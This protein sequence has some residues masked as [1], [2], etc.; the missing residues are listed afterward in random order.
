MAN[1]LQTK[2]DA[3]LA[4]KNA[5]LSPSNLKKGITLLGV[6]GTLGGGVDLTTTNLTPEELLEKSI[7]YGTFYEL[8]TNET[9]LTGAMK[10][11]TGKYVP[12]INTPSNVIIDGMFEDASNLVGTNKI[13]TYI[14]LNALITVSN[15]A[16]MKGTFKN[17]TSITRLNISQTTGLF[18]DLTSLFEGCTALVDPTIK[19]DN[20]KIMNRMY[21]GC[22]SLTTPGW[23]MANPFED[24]TDAFVGC[25][26]LT[27]S[28]FARIAAHLANS[29][30]TY[31]GVRTL[32]AIGLT[33]SQAS[34][35]VSNASSS[36]YSSQWS[37]MQSNGWTTGY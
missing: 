11:F 2:L 37:T 25:S 13:T 35:F 28:G 27:S 10:G 4:D 23:Y 5:N 26:S 3:I 21:Y 31:T 18:E 19:G 34:S 7:L 36:G 12:K 9:D 20:I 29:V 32:K 6:T 22:S 16:S 1:E 30:S 8:S 14:D 17:C 33:S 15:I 24:A